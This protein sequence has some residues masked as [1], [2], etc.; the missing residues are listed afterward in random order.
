MNRFGIQNDVGA[1]EAIE[2]FDGKAESVQR[3]LACAVIHVSEGNGFGFEEPAKLHT[4]KLNLIGKICLFNLTKAHFFSMFELL[5][6]K[7]VFDGISIAR[8]SS[9]FTGHCHFFPCPYSF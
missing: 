1:N 7:A 9:T 5:G 2:A 6:V 4:K 3:L 8:L